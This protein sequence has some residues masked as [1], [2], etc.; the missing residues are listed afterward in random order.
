MPRPGVP[1]FPA[2]ARARAGPARLLT[3]SASSQ[4]VERHCRVLGEAALPPCPLS[5]A[6]R[7]AG[8]RRGLPLPCWAGTRPGR[9]QAQSTAQAGVW[10]RRRRLNARLLAGR[11]SFAGRLAGPCC[12]QRTTRGPS[13]LS[14]CPAPR[15]CRP[16][17]GGA[18]SSANGRARLGQ[19]PGPCAPPPRFIGWADLGR[20]GRE[21]RN[22]QA[23]GRGSCRGAAD[24]EC[25]SCARPRRPGRERK[26]GVCCCGKVGPGPDGEPTA[27]AA[28]E[29]PGVRDAGQRGGRWR[30]LAADWAW[31][32]GAWV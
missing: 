9:L 27:C 31:D 1:A 6:P 2:P 21:A 18:Q 8:R 23:G 19:H 26:P 4:K 32:P 5:L 30:A 13:P 14:A 29:L 17:S 11:T 28:Q 22:R 24:K 16:G 20:A 3:P 25:A 15:T 12:R 7:R 10:R